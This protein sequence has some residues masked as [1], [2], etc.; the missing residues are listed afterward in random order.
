MARFSAAL[1]AAALLGQYA[2]GAIGGAV[3]QSGAIVTGGETFNSTV[4]A[5]SNIDCGSQLPWTSNPNTSFIIEPPRFR[6]T[7]TIGQARTYL[8]CKPDDEIIVNRGADGDMITI[9]CSER[10]EAE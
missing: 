10:Q 8:G 5:L 2:F 6:Q 4:C 7:L 1:C 3:A 9:S